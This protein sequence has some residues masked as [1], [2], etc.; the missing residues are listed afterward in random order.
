MY[1]DPLRSVFESNGLIFEGG[2]TAALR[3]HAY[4]VIRIQESHYVAIWGHQGDRGKQQVESQ[5]EFDPGG[6]FLCLCAVCIPIKSIHM[7]VD[8]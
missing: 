1:F 5:H 6:S 8:R 4:I 7:I 2:A 3:R